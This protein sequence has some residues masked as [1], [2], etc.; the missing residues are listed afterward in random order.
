LSISKPF[1]KAVR[2]SRD[3]HYLSRKPKRE[4]KGVYTKAIGARSAN[5]ELIIRRRYKFYIAEFS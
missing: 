2:A 1:S 5:K 3:V 4:R